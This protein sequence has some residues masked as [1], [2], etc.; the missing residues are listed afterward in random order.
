MGL[1][2]SCPRQAK[3]VNPDVIRVVHLN[4]QVDKFP[5]PVSLKQVLQHHPRHFIC[6]S[7]DLYAVNCRP[8]Q[9]AE[10]LRLGELYFLLPFSALESDLSA[11]NLMALAARLLAAARKEA[12]RAVRLRRSADSMWDLPGEGCSSMNGNLGRKYNDPE[13]KT[14]LGRI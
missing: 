8:L 10:E 2:V 5:S 9:T 7:R 1:I 11:E 3:V 6:H 13:V 4:G 14:A 12:S